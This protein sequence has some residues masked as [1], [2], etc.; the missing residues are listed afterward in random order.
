MPESPQLP[1]PPLDVTDDAPWETPL[2]R[3][4][5]R[6]LVQEV[7]QV[8]GG[9]VRAGNGQQHGWDYT[10]VAITALSS[11]STALVTRRSSCPGRTKAVVTT[12]D[13]PRW[14]RERDLS[15][16]PYDYWVKRISIKSTRSFLVLHN[17]LVPN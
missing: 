3:S 1:A 14:A 12:A 6:V 16:K 4:S 2:G 8:C 11:L 13:A 5:P 7:A 15:R 17:F 9:M 10:K